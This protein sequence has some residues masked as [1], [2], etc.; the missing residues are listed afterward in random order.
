M[1]VNSPHSTG[2]YAPSSPPRSTSGYAITS[3]ICGILGWTLFP[4]LG[5]LAAII[6]GHIARAEIRREPDK[7]GDGMAVAGLILGYLSLL[8][9]VVV[10]IVVLLFF[11]GWLS[12]LATMV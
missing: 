7:D 8:V 10:M 2:A 1:N 5:S 6:F 3:L 12:V 4:L 11:L 9:S